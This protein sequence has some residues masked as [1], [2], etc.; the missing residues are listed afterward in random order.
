VWNCIKDLLETSNIESPAYPLSVCLLTALTELQPCWLLSSR[1]CLSM[2]T[3]I[4][5][6]KIYS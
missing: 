2:W 6:C 4:L 1:W 5:L 3:S